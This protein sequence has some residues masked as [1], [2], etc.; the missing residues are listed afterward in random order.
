MM[1]GSCLFLSAKLG[2]FCAIYV[3]FL[4]FYVKSIAPLSSL[5]DFGRI[6]SPQT[7]R[8]STMRHDKLEKEMN[9]ML[10]L[11]EN[12]RYDVDAICDRIGIS[13]RMLYYYLESFRDWGFKVE[14]S[15]KIYSLDRESPFFKHLFETINFTEEE[16][17]T[18]LSILNKV[19]GNNAIVERLRRKLDRFYDLKILSNPQVREQAAH[20]VSV[21]YDA[22]KRHRLVK[23][24]GY[25]SPHSKSMSD[26]VVEPF[27][28]MN[29]N[30]DVR[31]YELQSGMNK[32]FKVSRMT[33]VVMLD[34]EW[35]NE[36]RHKQV[37]TDLFMFSGEERLPVKLRL[38]LLA[39]NLM[40]EEYPKST[41]FIVEEALADE[42]D[43][44]GNA[45]DTSI[46]AP[47]KDAKH[48]IFSA[49]F[50]SY[51]GISRFVLGLYNHIDVLESREFKEYLIE[52]V[53][54]MQDRTGRF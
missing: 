38:D 43:G 18:M 1:T 21:L 30:N 5:N 39:Y 48:W 31:C 34:L 26:R 53:Q 9:L 32:T 44:A 23:I 42:A 16:A 37:F 33:D 19:E 50:A 4:S 40:I 28:M 41:D 45:D 2:A 24:M 46:V 25:S 22:I 6:F 7:N 51:I 29:N 11:T 54:K 20:N 10:L 17:L 36:A 27:L 52:E 15:G 8:Y 47:R 14:K 49:D 13:R 12:H 3:H 35:G